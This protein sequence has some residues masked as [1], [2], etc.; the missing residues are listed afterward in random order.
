MKK[1]KFVGLLSIAMLGILSI[2]KVSAQPEAPEG[3]V[4]KQV[5]NN[6]V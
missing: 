2:S 4:W 5:R 1:I 3:F 6:F